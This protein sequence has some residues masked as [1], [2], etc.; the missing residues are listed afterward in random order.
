MPPR[1]SLKRIHNG[2]GEKVG[3][4]KTPA[5]DVIHDKTPAKDDLED[6]IKTINRTTAWH[7]KPMREIFRFICRIFTCGRKN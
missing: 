4:D 5:N 2:R 7:G 1:N 6:K 3:E